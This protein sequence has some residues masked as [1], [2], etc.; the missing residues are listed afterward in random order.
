MKIK[1][2]VCNMEGIMQI[3]KTNMEREKTNIITTHGRIKGEPNE[4]M[5]H[6]NKRKETHSKFREVIRNKIK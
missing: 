6:A 3:R 2:D 1:K 4:L 5:E